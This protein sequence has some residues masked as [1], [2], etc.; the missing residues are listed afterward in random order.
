MIINLSHEHVG[1]LWLSWDDA[2]EQLT[3]ENSRAVLAAARKFHNA[4]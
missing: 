3:F 2:A 4:A 1:F